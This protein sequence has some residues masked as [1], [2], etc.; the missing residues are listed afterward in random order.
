MT[1]LTLKTHLGSGGEGVV[2]AAG[3]IDLASAEQLREELR[4]TIERGATVLD[5]AEVAFC[6][7]SGLRVLLES[8]RLARQHGTSLR[9][10]APSPAV[11]RL[12]DI[13]EAGSVLAVYP[14]VTSALAG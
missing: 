1:T 5:L 12:L 6:D 10:A 8:D 7:S 9:L 11:E 4:V 13:T 2:Q 14:D 3:D